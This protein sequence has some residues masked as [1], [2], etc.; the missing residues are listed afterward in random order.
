M[1]KIEGLSKNFGAVKAVVNCDL[2]LN[3]G[4]IYGLLGPNGSGK[5]TLMKMVAGL[6]R[7]SSGTI[8]FEGDKIDYTTK[9]HIAYMATE[10]FIYEYMNLK[11]V[12]NYFGDFFACCFWG[13]SGE[14]CCWKVVFG[15]GCSDRQWRCDYPER[16]Q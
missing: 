12:A 11:E 8:L 14:K 5:S 7:P 1:I 15:Y 10:S 4:K 13:W 3:K 9:G 6:F 2:E 16:S